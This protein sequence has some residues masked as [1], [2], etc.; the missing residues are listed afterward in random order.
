MI[1]HQIKPSGQQTANNQLAHQ[2]AHQP[3]SQLVSQG[4]HPHDIPD[5]QS[6]VQSTD[7][8][9]GNEPV[10]RIVIQPDRKT[11]KQNQNTQENQ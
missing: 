7:T 4:S 9:T 3:F 6:A 5:S 8:W 2:R 10:S 11:W 1:N